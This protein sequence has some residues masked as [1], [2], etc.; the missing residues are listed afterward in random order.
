MMTQS[1]VT[2]YL[3]ETFVPASWNRDGDLTSVFEKWSENMCLVF[4]EFIDEQAGDVDLSRVSFFGNIGSLGDL[5]ALEFAN[6]VAQRPHT[7]FGLMNEEYLGVKYSAFLSELSTD[8]IDKLVFLVSRMTV[9]I[10]RGMVFED[11]F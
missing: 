6:V 8:G 11:A 4:F 3:N 2:A 9:A 5:D 1:E 7:S 10:E